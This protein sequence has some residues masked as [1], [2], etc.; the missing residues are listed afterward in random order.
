MHVDEGVL[1][2]KKAFGK[3]NKLPDPESESIRVKIR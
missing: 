3:L 1:N 2:R